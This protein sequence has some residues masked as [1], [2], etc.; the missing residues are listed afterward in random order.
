MDA[1]FDIFQQYKELAHDL[2]HSHESLALE[3]GQHLKYYAEF[4]RLSRPDSSSHMR[5]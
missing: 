5:A 3:I 2:F 4:A 1:I